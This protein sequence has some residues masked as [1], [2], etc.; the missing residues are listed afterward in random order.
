M[1]FIYNASLGAGAGHHCA[2]GVA[3]IAANIGEFLV[4]GYELTQDS[5]MPLF[6]EVTLRHHGTG[7]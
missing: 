1:A 2:H 6:K 5:E 3:H 4:R 7:Y